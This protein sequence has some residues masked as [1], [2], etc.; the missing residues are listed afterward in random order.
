[1]RSNSYG[2]TNCCYYSLSHTY[3]FYYYCHM[4]LRPPGQGS[5]AFLRLYIF[6][7]TFSYIYRE[8]CQWE[9]TREAVLYEQRFTSREQYIQLLFAPL[10]RQ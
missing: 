9:M 3:Y 2:V 6:M 7:Y 1:M 8:A 5:V 4:Q 10:R